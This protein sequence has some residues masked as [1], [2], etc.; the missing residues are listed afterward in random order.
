MPTAI[1]RA[2]RDNPDTLSLRSFLFLITLISNLLKFSFGRREL[3]RKSACCSVRPRLLKPKALGTEVCAAE[4]SGTPLSVSQNGA[5]KEKC[6][7][8]KISPAARECSHAQSSP[9]LKP[10]PSYPILRV[11]R[12]PA[13]CRS[14][15]SLRLL[16]Q[17]R[18]RREALRFYLS[19]ASPGSRPLKDGCPSGL[20]RLSL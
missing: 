20:S 11:D 13:G 4:R 8:G 2:G 10:W 19:F 3:V 9:F 6:L 15:A 5:D 1:Q 16:R 18:R 17:R 7:R 12:Q 14:R